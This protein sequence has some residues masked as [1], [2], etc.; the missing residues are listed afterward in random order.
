MRKLNGV[1]RLSDGDAQRGWSVDALGYA[2]HWNSTDQVPLALIRSGQLCRFCALDPTDGGRTAR[3]IL[4]GEWHASDDAGYLKVSGFAEHYRLQLWSNFTYAEDNPVQGDQFNQRDARNLFGTR[5]AKGWTHTLFGRESS[6]ELGLQVRHDQIHVSLLDSQARIAFHTVSSDLVGET[7]GGVYA[8][9]ATTWSRWFRSLVGLRA[10]AIDLNLRSNVYAPN[11]GSVTDSRISPKLALIFGPWAKTEF[12][13][14]AGNGFHSNDARGVVN[15]FDA[16]T[17][18]PVTRAP[19]LVGSFGKEI[20]ARTEIIP[21]LQSSLALWRLDSSSEL[22]YGADSG[23]TEINGASKRY[24]VE[25]NNHMIVNRWL[26]FDADLAWTHAR[27]AHADENDAVGDHIPNAVGKVA[28]VGLT[29]HRVGPWSADVKVLYIGGYPLSQD[30][31]LR[32]PSS[33]VTNLRVQRELSPHVS[34]SLD[35]LNVFDRRYFD[36][37]Y[38]Q[39]YRVSPASPLVP[40]G[41]TVHPGEPREARLTLSLK[42]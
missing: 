32:A 41:V 27:Y 34:L 23:G 38:E 40:D 15:R 4:S 14:N 21:G 2:A 18:D 19:A 28:S 37:A 42:L 35:V 6:T 10:D 31:R 9:N 29:A 3:E 12:F 36:I 26:L 13:V 1:L 8:E 39:D 22:V 11:H 33:L 30:G 16:T 17:G 25:W 20:G 7:L 5:I 24:G